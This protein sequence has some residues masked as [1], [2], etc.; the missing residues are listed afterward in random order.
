MEQLVTLKFGNGSLETGLHVILQI[1]E[2]GQLPTVELTGDLPPAV[3]LQHTLQRWQRAYRRMGTPYRLEAK[4]GF[5]KNVSRIDDCDTVARQLNAEFNRWLS[6]DSFRPL[7]D[8]L[9][10]RLNPSDYIRIVLQTEL[11]TLQRLPWHT[12]AL[13]DRY[14]KAEIALSAPAYERIERQTMP[15]S[16]VRILAILGH[17]QGLELQT[18]QVLLNQ[19]PQADV[20]FLVEPDRQQLNDVLWDPQGWDILFFAGH[21][22]SQT[23]SATD[24]TGKLYL[25][26]DD[27]LTVPELKHGLSKAIERGLKIAI[28][29]SCDGLGL[30]HDLADLQIPQVLVMREPV[31][32]PVAHMFLKSFLTTFS[33]QVP[34][35]LAV[36]EAREKLQGLEDKYPCATWLPMIYQHLVEQPPTWP[37]PQLD[38]IAKPPLNITQQQQTLGLKELL[39]IGIFSVCTTLGL[40]QTGI[41]Q[42]WE[43]RGFDFL[44][45]RRSHQLPDPRLLIITVTEADIQA[46]DA[47]QRRGS[48]SDDALSA[49][50]EKLEPMQPR[51]IGLDIYRDFPV[52]DRQ[53]QLINQ[54]QLPNLIATCQS[55]NSRDDSPGIASP[56]EVPSN[57]V[58]FS[59]VLTDADGI[60]RRQLLSIT[61][62]PASP[63]PASYSLNA[64]IA[65]H[66]L[67]AQGM[68]ITVTPEGHLQAGEVIF[69][70]LEPHSGGYQGMDAGGHQILLN[71]RH[72]S[73]PDQIADQVTLDEV[74]A[75]RVSDDIVRDRIVLIGTTATSFGDYWLTPYSHGHM[76]LQETAGVFLQA[77]MVSHLLSTVLDGHPLIRTWP[78]WAEILW[79]VSWTT[80]G[81]VA[82]YGVN[83]W[84]PTQPQWRQLLLVGVV[85][86]FSLLSL[87]WFSLTRFGYWLPWVSVSTVIII[88]VGSVATYRRFQSAHV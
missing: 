71:Y 82:I 15:R 61:P 75:G 68:D 59:D 16:R 53:P 23:Q 86:Q 51:V 28:F 57:Q 65:L 67:S 31:P 30:A 44:M 81:G 29:N 14:P 33:R 63:C 11:H 64:L 77:H 12:W 3:Q 70:P 43:L 5:A 48:L 58:G 39:I 37:A 84:I 56:P 8:K 49:L 42:P 17:G 2:S 80:L 66:Y 24:I 4:T 74:L 76:G 7:Y 52:S 22:S 47:D 21:S 26:P 32:D 83:I 45:Q 36:R 13:C 54:L 72:L 35:Y 40:R 50:L 9:L 73:S 20:Q 25:N 60:T 1:G 78:D 46:Q 38:N 62:E 79:I 87:C 41:L 6:S 18:D 34:F 19:L 10:E 27:S 88:T 69:T 85:A 55:R